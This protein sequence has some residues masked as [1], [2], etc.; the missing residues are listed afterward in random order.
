MN[1]K[2]EPA[3]GLDKPPSVSIEVTFTPGGPPT[4]EPIDLSPKPGMDPRVYEAMCARVRELTP[5]WNALE[6]QAAAYVRK[7]GSQPLDSQTVN[8]HSIS[9]FWLR[10]FADSANTIVQMDTGGRDVSAEEAPVEETA[11]A[12]HQFTLKQ[13]LGQGSRYEAML[14]Y[15]EN[16]AS[17]Y[18]KNLAADKAAP[19][20][21]FHRWVLSYYFAFMFVQSTPTMKY[22]AAESSKRV[23]DLAAELSQ[24]GLVVDQDNL[25]DVYTHK[26][27][28]GNNPLINKIAF[29]FFCRR[30]HVVEMPPETPLALPLL[31]V[32]H[33]GQPLQYATDIWV[34]VSPSVLLCMS[35]TAIPEIPAGETLPADVAD[36]VIEQIIKHATDHADGVLLLRPQDREWWQQRIRNSRP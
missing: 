34:P 19:A 10:L 33:W 30:W 21:D 2:Q 9:Q 8:Q 20:E 32:I 7:A 24:Q 17:V 36:R 35:W 23:A 26:G 25:R 16:K 29:Y 14:S 1:D 27:S 18:L 31:P 3:G 5:R 28:I 11:S 22:A 4:Q 15:V 6:K 13:H 12:P